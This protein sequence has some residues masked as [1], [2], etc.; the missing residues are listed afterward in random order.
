MIRGRD[1]I[2]VSSID[3]DTQ[4]QAP[5]ELALR[6]SAAGNRVLYL[7]NTGVRTPG[8]R[9][10]GRVMRR[11]KHWA[12]ALLAHGVRPVRPNLWV[13]APLVLPP[14]G[15]APGARFNRH[16]LLPLIARA[17]R[18]LGMRD[19]VIWSFLP[20][21]TALG[22]LDL[23][24][25]E[26]GRVVYYCAADFSQLTP[27]AHGLERS[28]AEL[29]RRSD[30]VFTIC[31]E[32]AERCRRWNSNVHV[33]PYGVNLKAFPPQAAEHAPHAAATRNGHHN[34]FSWTKHAKG[35]GHR[36]IGYVGGLHRH[37]GV[38]ML[39]EMASA[40]PAWSWVF[41]GAPEV[42]LK[43]LQG[44]PNVYLLGQRPHHELARYIRTFDVCIVPYRRSAYTETV[45]PSKIN[46]YLAM[47]KP[48]VS[49]D[50]P[51]VC[52]FNDKHRVLITAEGHPESFLR[53]IERALT[54]VEDETLI[55]RRREV[56][57]QGDWEARL[58]AMSELILRDRA[59]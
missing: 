23:L 52:D 14:F 2:L 45:V 41:V 29:L 43:D 26:H 55:E 39:V 19:P 59:S 17:A 7:E 57:R 56:A 10:A 6:L 15:P 47:G 50:L 30:V 54:H 36:V 28:E 34:G 40:R 18:R 42:P 58:D 33:F 11:L 20:T 13:Y 3:W 53:G 51:P 27:S 25:S 21:D 5:Q 24:G 38:E 16:L 12:G 35:N 37:V 32:L 49:T 46:E 31:D 4:W 48:V 8:L 44:L 22:L 1:I 9:D